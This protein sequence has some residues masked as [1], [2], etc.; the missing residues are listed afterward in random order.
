MHRQGGGILYRASSTLVEVAWV[1][2]PASSPASSSQAPAHGEVRRRVI[3]PLVEGLSSIPGDNDVGN[4]SGVLT[5]G[6]TT[7]NGARGG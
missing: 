1:V 4:S 7:R 5:S 6:I 3:P 2:A